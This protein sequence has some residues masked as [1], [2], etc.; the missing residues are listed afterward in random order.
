MYGAGYMG[1]HSRA[2]ANLA[3]NLGLISRTN[4]VDYNHL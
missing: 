3:G 4:T 1:P 2:L